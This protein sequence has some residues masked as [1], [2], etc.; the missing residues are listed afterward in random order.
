MSPDR[1]ARSS[2]LRRALAACRRSFLDLATHSLLV[3]ILGDASDI[4][5]YVERLVAHQLVDG[6][7]DLG[8]AQ[9]EYR[10]RYITRTEFITARCFGP[11]N[12]RLHV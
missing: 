11:V 5:K 12:G 2:A 1:R 4:D 3:D 6:A 7:L 9:K 10:C 8:C